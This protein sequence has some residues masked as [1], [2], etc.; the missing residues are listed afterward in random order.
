MYHQMFIKKLLFFSS[1]LLLHVRPLVDDGENLRTPDYP[2]FQLCPID[3]ANHGAQ[4]LK[5]IRP[6]TVVVVVFD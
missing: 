2:L 3:E 4:H 1:S 6:L 5:S